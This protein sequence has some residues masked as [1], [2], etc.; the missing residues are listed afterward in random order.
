MAD[1]G[2]AISTDPNIFGILGI[3]TAIASF[4]SMFLVPYI[5]SVQAT[6]KFRA[7]EE[8]R[9]KNFEEKLQQMKETIVDANHEIKVIMERSDG[10]MRRILE[11]MD[12]RITEI[13]RGFSDLQR[14]YDNLKPR[15]EAVE[16]DYKARL[17]HELALL[18]RRKQVGVL[19]SIS[20]ISD[21]ADDLVE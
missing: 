1:G 7:N 16:D 20:D 3:I 15:F 19:S 10:D 13:G 11:K 9:N 18:R 17:R 12:A 14:S 5:R 21:D 8:S 2:A 4:A 6:A